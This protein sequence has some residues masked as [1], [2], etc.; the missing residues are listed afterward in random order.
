[1]ESS[2]PASAIRR[3][4]WRRVGP[5]APGRASLF[6]ACAIL[7]ALAAVAIFAPWI[8]PKNPDTVD[9][10]AIANAPSMEH[11]LGT[12]SIGRDLLSRLIMGSR[13]SLLVG[14]SAVVI[15]GCIGIPLGLV[16]GYVGGWLDEIVARVIDIFLAFPTFLLAL[17][18]VAILGPGTRNVILALGLTGW[19]EFCRVARAEAIAKRE[20]DYIEASRASGIRA[21]RLLFVHLMPNVLPP[22]IVLATLR[23]GT[24]I[25]SEAGLSFLGLGVQ[26]PD[27]SWGTILADG[28]PYLSQAPHIM[29]SAGLAIMISVLAINFVG[30]YR[31]DRLDA[32]EGR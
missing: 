17:A 7:V 4:A 27:A 26:P 12:D 22:L 6:V 1:M 31:R 21:R 10:L 18:I 14:F 23:V 28:R 32:V 15:A 11:W 13:V 20:L 16:I 8:T 25:I 3:S 29:T 24:A 30:D 2:T 19:T 9:Y 5:R